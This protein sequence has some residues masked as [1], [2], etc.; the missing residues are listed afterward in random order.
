MDT[1]KLKAKIIEKGLNQDKVAK[2][3]GITLQTFNAKLNGRSPWTLENI[4]KLKE[5]LNLQNIE[6]FFLDNMSQ[7]SNDKIK[8]EK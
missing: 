3:M 6:E 8:E 4:L 1:L 7:I 5:I 2:K